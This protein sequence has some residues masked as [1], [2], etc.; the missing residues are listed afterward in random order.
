MPFT[1]A[2]MVTKREEYVDPITYVQGVVE[3]IEDCTEA[4][5]IAIIGWSISAATKS[6]TPIYKS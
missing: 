2:A 5:I 3:E 1:T 4:S 6:L